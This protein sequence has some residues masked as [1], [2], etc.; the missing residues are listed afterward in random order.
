MYRDRPSGVAIVSR[1]HLEHQPTLDDLFGPDPNAGF[2]EDEPLGSNPARWFFDRYKVEPADRDDI[3]HAHNR[4]WVGY[5][6]R[7]RPIR[8]FFT[9]QLT[10]VEGDDGP[11][12]RVHAPSLSLYFRGRLLN[13][14][15]QEDARV[16]SIRRE[17][18]QARE[19]AEDRNRSAIERSLDLETVNALEAILAVLPG[20][21]TAEALDPDLAGWGITVQADGNGPGLFTPLC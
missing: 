5:A 4:L 2:G 12:I 6:S 21:T 15:Y 8:L 9:R 20:A 11:P 16:E 19:R 10:W 7:W 13:L 1:A 17:L 14:K 18:A 3:E